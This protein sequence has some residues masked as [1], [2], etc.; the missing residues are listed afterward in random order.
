MTDFSGF[1]KLTVAE[2]QRRVKEHAALTDAELAILSDTGALK[3]ELADRM[4]ENVIGAVHLP[5]GLATNF[6]INGK[7]LVIPMALEEPSV[8][9]AACRA[10]KLALPEGFRAEADNPV[11][12]G[13]VQLVGV[14]DLDQAI[15][16]LDRNRAEII[17]IADEYMKPH[18]KWGGK[19]LDFRARVLNSE[20]KQM[21]LVEFD[22]NVS[23]AMGANMVNTTLEGVAPTLAVLTEGNVRLRIIT[24]LATKRKVRASAVWKKGVIGEETIE[25]ILD[26]YELAK[27]DIYRCSTHNKGVM[28]GIDAVAMATC[29]DWRAVEA[30]A[31]TFAAMGSYHPLTRYEKTAKGDLAG[32][33]ELPMAVATIGGGV[34]SSP[35]ARIALKIAGIR[36][37]R[38][39]AMAMACVGLANNFAAL[40]ALSTVGIQSGHMKLHA[41][42]VAVIAGAETPEEIDAVAAEL[43]EQK[44]FSSEN[45]KRILDRMRSGK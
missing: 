20:V 8:I 16:N 4:I 5:L 41:K 27:A 23:D 15:K 1:Y 3:L 37:S 28:N 12:I 39:L 2:R 13:Q 36:T 9:A 7:D 14:P 10:A 18:A 33:I 29:N 40:A 38:E 45:A 22:I 17:R 24:N 31:H 42:N 35:T 26:G 32:S 6:R 21:L 44:D 30:G 34:N 43:A 25:G 19:V 11:M